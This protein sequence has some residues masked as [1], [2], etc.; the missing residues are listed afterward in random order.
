MIFVEKD[1][2]IEIIM[3]SPVWTGLD[4]IARI[5]ALHSIDIVRCKE[6]KH[7]RKVEW[8]NERRCAMHNSTH[9][10]KEDDFCSN[11][12]RNK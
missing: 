1:E 12:E 3:K 5:N 10:T 8:S 2:L 7:W 9:S 4:A 6:C 11:G